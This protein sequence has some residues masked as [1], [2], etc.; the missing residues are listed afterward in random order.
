MNHYEAIN[1]L[2]TTIHKM[3]M[4]DVVVTCDS[5]IRTRDPILIGVV[6][7]AKLVKARHDVQLRRSL[8]ETTFTVADG[9]PV[10]WLSALCG[11]RLPGRVA[12]IDVMSE[13]LALADRQ[14]YGVFFLGATQEVVER[15]V[16][17]VRRNYPGA[18]IAGYH[19][20][21]FKGDQE[22]AM[23]EMI[24]ASHADILL[25]AVPTPKKENFL[26]KWRQ[27]MEV[28]VCHGVG[29]SF[30]VVAGITRRAPQW[31]QNWGLEWLYR[32]LQE[33]GRMWKRYLVTNTVFIW[34]GLGEIFRHRLGH[35]PSAAAG[36]MCTTSKVSVDARQ[37]SKV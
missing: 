10:V 18:R 13:L 36:P 12:G 2:G 31:M 3:D 21:Y 5:S 32:V 1:L 23:A 6:N 34:S 4:S 29:G 9:V 35:A 33:P 7:A 37:S 25:V 30:D 14:K 26:S 20:G 24:R 16:E 8:A 19:D 22:Q 28:P 27:Y 11:C 15:V 17:H